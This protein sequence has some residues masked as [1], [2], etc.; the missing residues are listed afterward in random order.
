MT[1]FAP[2]C[3]L[4]DYGVAFVK[5]GRILKTKGARIEQIQWSRVLDGVSTASV[6]LVTA[7]ANCC[8]NLAAVDHWNTDLVIFATNPE[9]GR[10]EVIWR[11]P[12]M[13]PEYGRGV[14]RFPAT[15]VLRWTQV[16][17]S[18]N[19]LTFTDQD[20]SDIFVG[21]WND[22]IVNV[23]P[24]Y[25]I[26]HELVVYPSGVRES[27]VVDGD[28][29]RM[30]WNIVSEMLN[31]GLDVTTFGSKV[32]VGLPPFSPIDLKDTDVEG[33]VRV[34]KDGDAFGNRFVGNAA[35]DII[36]VWPE[37]PRE[38]REGYPLVEGTVV[39][40]QLPDAASAQAAAKA[41]Y[42]FA[43]GGVRRVQVPGGLILKPTA[44]IN[45]KRLL[46]GQLFNF[47]ATETCYT[48]TETLRLGR[49]EVTVTKGRER[50][51]ID[52]QPAGALQDGHTLSSV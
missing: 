13:K 50:A 9:T 21:L 8:G 15:D 23:D 48:A 19:D 25:P 10:K 40:S 1:T 42:D 17:L 27:R 28:A 2:T 31:S 36:G 47:S 14:T 7:G 5:G 38:G 18:A 29:L 35:R 20:V 32:I 22:A 44:K 46:A 26:D 6:D 24:N 34:V 45:V 11:G 52:L 30:F 43:E 16:R 3:T 37:G 39:D 41:R 12:C 33:D 4:E 51:M 49:L